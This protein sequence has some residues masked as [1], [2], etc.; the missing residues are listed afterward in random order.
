MESPARP[1][2]R[3]SHTPGVGAGVAADRRDQP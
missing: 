1:S 3:S 2:I